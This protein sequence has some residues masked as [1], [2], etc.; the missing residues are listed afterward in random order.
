MEA[1]IIT[2]P[3]DG[4]DREEP[5]GQRR[6][7]WREWSVSRLLESDFPARFSLER[8]CVGLGFTGWDAKAKV[9]R[10]VGFD[11]DGMLGHKAGLTEEQLRDIERRARAIPWVTVRRSKSGKGLH[12]YVFFKT[13][14][15]TADRYEHIALALAVLE[16]LSR[17]AGHDFQLKVDAKGVVLWVWHREMGQEGFALLHQGE[18]LDPAEI[19]DGWREGRGRRRRGRRREATHRPREDWKL[20][21]SSTSNGLRATDSPPPGSKRKACSGRTPSGSRSFAKPR[22]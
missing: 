11:Y 1:Q 14:I 18:P 12:L 6:R 16:L 10:W 20:H 15:P 8:R 7:G 17:E 22:G 4:E 3:E 21:T 2:S 5:L 19:P 9:S 13:P